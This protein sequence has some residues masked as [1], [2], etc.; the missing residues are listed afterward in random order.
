MAEVDQADRSEPG[1]SLRRLLY[2]VPQCSAARSTAHTLSSPNNISRLLRLLGL[3]RVQAAEPGTILS[4]NNQWQQHKMNRDAK[5]I[6]E[7]ATEDL[8]NQ[9]LVQS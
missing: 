9:E 2:S 7:K 4:K 1:S 3:V 8:Q 6:D 5:Q